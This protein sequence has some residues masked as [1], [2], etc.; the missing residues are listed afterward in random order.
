[1]VAAWWVKAV[2]E[3][4]CE[5][6]MCA[7]GFHGNRDAQG[8]LKELPVRDGGPRREGEAEPASVGITADFAPET[9]RPPLF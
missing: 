8:S 5:R 9:G 3:R 7:N 2:P 1:M 6:I 4:V